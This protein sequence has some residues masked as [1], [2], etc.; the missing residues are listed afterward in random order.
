MHDVRVVL[1]TAPDTET[2][3]RLG[4]ALVEEHLAACATVVPDVSSTYWWGGRVERAGEALVILKTTEGRVNDLRD[5]ALGLHPY[6]VPELLVLQVVDGNDAYLDW[7]RRES[8][9]PLGRTE[10]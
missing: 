1:M 8:R 5:R 2:A 9:P 10:T 6:E 3:E 4:R 7:V